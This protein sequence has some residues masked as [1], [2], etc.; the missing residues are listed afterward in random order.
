MQRLAATLE[1]FNSER[2][3]E[4]V[5]QQAK[6]REKTSIIANIKRKKTLKKFWAS[7]AGT[8]VK[9]KI[10]KNNL[11]NRNYSNVSEAMKTFWNSEEGIE[12]R[13]TIQSHRKD[14]PRTD[15]VKDKISLK[16]Q[17]HEVSQETRDIVSRTQA[18]RKH[19]PEQ[20][21]K[22]MVGIQESKK[23]GKYWE[24]LQK[25]LKL[26][27]NKFEQ[28]IAV[29]LPETFMYTGDFNPNG[30]FKFVDGRNKNADFTLFPERT[31]VVECFGDYWHG[32]RLNNITKEEHANDVLDNYREIGVNCL[33]IWENELNDITTLKNKIDNFLMEL[34]E[35]IK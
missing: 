26:R 14:I 6:S 25:G 17:G 8:V 28:K 31:K 19:S 32:V 35:I 12:K 1:F 3:V 9:V 2:G 7:E 33:I 18:G 16:L 10:S 27:P 34:K 11:E 21:A 5:K 30:M 23:N 4:V 20:I 15:A 13:K 24:N 22:R 29:L